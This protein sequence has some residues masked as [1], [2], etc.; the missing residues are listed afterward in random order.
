MAER[1]FLSWVQIAAKLVPLYREGRNLPRNVESLLPLGDKALG[2]LEEEGVTI[3]EVRALL[4]NA[5]PLVSL[6]GGLG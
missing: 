6:L 4:K 5:G 2:I 1:S 3:G